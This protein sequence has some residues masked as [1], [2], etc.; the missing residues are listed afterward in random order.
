MSAMGANA[1]GLLANIA[2]AP[3]PDLTPA[4]QQTTYAGCRATGCPFRKDGIG[5]MARQTNP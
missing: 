2:V 3:A 5:A 1:D 4:L